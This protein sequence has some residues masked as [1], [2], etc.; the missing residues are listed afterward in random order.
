VAKVI[1]G[2]RELSWSSTDY[3]EVKASNGTIE[4][5]YAIVWRGKSFCDWDQFEIVA[6]NPSEEQIMKMVSMAR[7]LNA[8]VVGDDGEIYRVRTGLLGGK[9]LVVEGEK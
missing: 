4:R 5:N 1:A 3:S 9:K 2:D 7:A 6:K 8:I